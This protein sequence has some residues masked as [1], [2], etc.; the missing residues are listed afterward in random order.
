MIKVFLLLFALGGSVGSALPQVKASD[1]SGASSLYWKAI[2]AVVHKREAIYKD[3][4]AFPPWRGVMI[5]KSVYSMPGYDFPSDFP[6]KSIGSLP[7]EYLTPDELRQ[8][9]LKVRKPIPILVV[10]SME[11]EGKE[12]KVNISD[13]WYE[14]TKKSNSYALEGGAVV[15]FSYDCQR[16]EFVVSSVEEWGI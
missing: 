14:F 7:V 9:Y 13:Y 4:M 8:R 6:R 11:N 16:Q 1:S 12:L 10:R 5:G 15:K 3:R 2:E